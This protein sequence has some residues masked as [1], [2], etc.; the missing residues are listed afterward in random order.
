MEINM[1]FSCTSTFILKQTSKKQFLK[2][3]YE[4]KVQILILYD[5]FVWDHLNEGYDLW[6]GARLQFTQLYQERAVKDLQEWG[7]WQ[8][9]QLRKH[10][11]PKIHMTCIPKEQFPR[12][13]INDQINHREWCWRKN[14]VNPTSTIM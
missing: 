9:E 7:H 11:L 10:H 4:K 14:P 3:L 8:Q 5:L 6:H 13:K 2:G 12:Y 1:I